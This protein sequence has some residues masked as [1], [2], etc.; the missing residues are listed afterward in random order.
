MAERKGFEPPLPFQ[1]DL[2]SNQAPS[3]TRP[4]LQVL[5]I[6]DKI[7]NFLNCFSALFAVWGTIG[8]H[9]AADTGD[10]KVMRDGKQVNR[11]K[12]NYQTIKQQA[13]SLIRWVSPLGSTLA[14]VIALAS[15]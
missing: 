6:T 4:P 12:Q 1:V 13:K 15:V 14:R 2:I 9:L 3:A 8:A 10:E 7:G 5:D 11:C